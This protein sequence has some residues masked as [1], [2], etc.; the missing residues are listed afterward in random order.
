MNK[1]ITLFLFLITLNAWSAE[2]SKSTIDC[3]SNEDIEEVLPYFEQFKSLKESSQKLCLDNLNEESDQQRY[4]LLKALVRLKKLDVSL[5]VESKIKNSDDEM[6]TQAIT[7]ESWWNYLTSRAN[8]FIIDPPRCFYSRGT[9][10]FVYGDSKSKTI[11]ICPL[12]FQA[13]ILEQIETLLHEVRHFD[14]HAHVVCRDGIY[15]NRGNS[16]DESILDGGSYAVTIQ[17]LV[18]LSKLETTTEY[19]RYL[20]ESLAVGRVNNNFN[21]KV[22][23]TVTKYAYLSNDEG[24]LYRA[25]IENLGKLELVKKLETPSLVYSSLRDLTIIPLDRSVD[26]TRLDR[27]FLVHAPDVGIF[28]SKYN[29]ESIEERRLYN[30]FNYNEVGGFLKDG[31]YYNSCGI[32]SNK[33]ESI[34]LNGVKLRSI[35]SLKNELGKEDTHIIDSEGSAYKVA[36]ISGIVSRTE[37]S[38]TEIKL[39]TSLVGGISKSQNDLLI[40]DESGEVLRFN[41]DKNQIY[42]TELAQKNWISITPH[43]VY[44]IFD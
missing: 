41:L 44:Q 31:A 14:G 25:D 27:K 2:A 35:V 11:N 33:A 9:M 7:T 6:N 34:E 23:T 20:L 36:C 42:P 19:E 10:A 32:G 21:K 24:E 30:Q 16:C 39:P 17:V 4:Y 38:K 3:L 22:K 43:E 40:L 13:N 8:N 29:E 26:A 1:L 28:A 5:S 37:I 18:A 12:F 15:K